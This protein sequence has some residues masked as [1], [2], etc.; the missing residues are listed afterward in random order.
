MKFTVQA[1]DGRRVTLEGD[2][3]PTEQELNQVFGI[4][5]QPA[6]T[7]S[8]NYALGKLGTIDRGLTFGLGRKAGGLINAI[9]SYPVNRIAELAGVKNTPSFWDEYHNIVDP[10]MQAINEFHEDRPVEATALELGAGIFNPAN[11]LGV[12]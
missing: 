3:T 2:H 4:S 8:K 5:E 7:Q 1:P 6:Q 12:G 10:T 9:G 11:K